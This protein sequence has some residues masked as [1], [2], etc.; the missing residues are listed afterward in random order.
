[1]T[2]PALARSSP[3]GQRAYIWPPTGEQFPS[4]TTI[5]NSLPKH[6][7]K[8]WAAKVVAEY[9]A[10]HINTIALMDRDAAIDLLKR[11]PLRSTSRAA[12]LGTTIHHHIEHGKPPDVVADEEAPYLA[13]FQAFCDDWQPEFLRQE[14]TV[15]N[16]SV[17]YAGTVDA[18]ARLPDHA[19]GNGGT[20]LLDWKTGKGV[21][22]EAAL[23]LAAYRSAE[24]WDLGDHQTET[25]P[26]PLHGGLIVHLTPDGYAVHRCDTSPATFLVFRHL[27]KVHHWLNGGNKQALTEIA[28]PTA[29]GDT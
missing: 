10:D 20:Y 9:A 27:V 22:P 24:W 13:A 3:T 21:Y 16:R 26:V 4:V 6:A 8:H 23:Q 17:G 29:T 1:M 25:K 19:A 11:E 14:I 18:T 5:L 2:S 7:L 15:F 12:S 28:H